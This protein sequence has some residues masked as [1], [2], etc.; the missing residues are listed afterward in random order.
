MEIKKADS[1]GRVSGFTPG[2]YYAIDREAGQFMRMAIAAPDGRP[3]EE[4][5]R[6]DLTSVDQT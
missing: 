1:K 2:D 4:A 6:E 5:L 3:V